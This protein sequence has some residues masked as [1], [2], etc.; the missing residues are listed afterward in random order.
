MKK[1]IY[2]ILLSIVFSVI[3]WVSISLS[4]EYNTMI[5]MPVKFINVPA[6][7][8]TTS[9]SS[10]QI[11]VKVRGKGWN[12]ITALLTTQK[13]YFVD[14]GNNLKKKK[15]IKL[16]SFSA[17][18]TWLTSKL[19]ILEI[20]PDTISF[21]FEEISSAKLKIVPNLQMEFKPGYGL[22]SDLVIIPESTTVS[23]PI[24]KI[25]DM[26]EITTE[27][28][29]IKNLSE[30]TEQLVSLKSIPELDYEA[31]TA[32]L[33][34]DVQRIVEKNIDGVSVRIHDIPFDR[35]VVLLPNKVNILLRG[36]INV[37]GKLN[38]EDI[39]ASVNY[40]DVVLD[41]IGSVIPM[42]NIPEHTELV[43][44]KPQ[45]LNYVIKK[46]KK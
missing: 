42:L 20:T 21:L 9:P 45:R 31:R 22:A 2:V 11:N 8:V 15:I 3:L 23:G 27:K 6:G 30:K 19:D 35:D 44:I 43:Y 33:L 13:D 28:I 1:N 40:R 12:L 34:I 32:K 26:K 10:E 25:V 37:L 5:E 4:S 17:E 39:T 24:N 7:Y 38:K 29:E 46:F 36:G 16:N 18:N 14:A 41:T